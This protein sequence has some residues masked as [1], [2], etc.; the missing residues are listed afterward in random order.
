MNVGTTTHS[1]SLIVRDAAVVPWALGAVLAAPVLFPAA[2]NPAVISA[3]GLVVGA[4]VCVFAALRGA[5]LARLATIAVT[6]LAVTG[7]WFGIT[8]ALSR[9]PLVSLWGTLGQHNGTM[10][11]A[12]GLAWLMAGTLICGRRQLRAVL[13]VTAVA[14]ALSTV[15]AVIE[16]VRGGTARGWGSAAGAFENSASL[17][18]FL[19]V[20]SFAAVAWALADRRPGARWT[21]LACL[22][23]ALAGMAVSES[24][25]A[26][27]GVVCALVAVGLLRVLAPRPRGVAVWSA[28]LPIAAMLVGAGGAAAAVGAL[29]ATGNGLVAAL[30]NQRDVIWTSAVGQFLQAPVSGA[31]LEQFSAWISWGLD[32][33]GTLTYNATYDPHSFG[34]AL[35]TGGGLIGAAL[36]LCAAIALLLALATTYD[37]A[38]RPLA[39]AVAVAVPAALLGSALVM[40]LTPAAVIATAAIA[41]S[42]LGAGAGATDERTASRV[43]TWIASGLPWFA[44]VT[45]IAIV[46]LCGRAVVAEATYARNEARDVATLASLYR[47]WPDPGYAAQSI[48]AQI[49]STTGAATP[50][51]LSPFTEDQQRWHVSLTLNALFYEQANAQASGADTWSGF[52]AALTRGR[53]ADPATAM[54]DTLGAL[55]AKRLGKD[56]EA[57]AYAA[58]ALEGRVSESTRAL[59]EDAR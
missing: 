19:A 16:V 47:A 41:G 15:L 46:A 20:A 38:G 22:A 11:F 37:R 48:D 53:E 2:A 12:L 28:G 32:A 7:L 5:R 27:L 59:L 45:A 14:G 36:W 34:L 23:L 8:S 33:G 42:V 17:G 57:A 31:G 24:R 56:D 44:A 39:V 3:V 43:A 51:D 25:A 35:V 13:A 21:A 4:C 49:A 54:W 1:G 6:P 29:G 40:W 58:R 18:Q 10:L 52:E 55:E 30:G 26:L 9:N 50:L